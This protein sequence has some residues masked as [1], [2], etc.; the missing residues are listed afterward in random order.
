MFRK[1]REKILYLARLSNCD[2][3]GNKITI[4][5]ISQISDMDTLG[6][7]KLNFSVFYSLFVVGNYLFNYFIY[8]SM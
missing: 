6:K 5:G 1:R 4:C 2:L 3:T 8:F 7:T